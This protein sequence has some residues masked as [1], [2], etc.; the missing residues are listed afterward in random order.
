MS[1]LH[2]EEIRGDVRI[3]EWTVRRTL[4]QIEKDGEEVH[5]EPKVMDLLLCLTEHRGQVVSKDVL[6]DRVWGVEHVS[7]GTLS[8]AVAELRRALGDDART[9]RY[10]ETIRKR[11]YR[12]IA[13][14]TSEHLDEPILS[15]DRRRGVRPAQW[16]VVLVLIALAVGAYAI[17]GLWIGR[18][19]TRPPR[20]VIL[21][22]ENFGEP[23]HGP[24]AAGLTDEVIG[25][26]ATVKQL[27]VI[28]ATTAFHY[29]SSG[30]SARDVARDLD[31][32]YIL[33][34]SVRWSTE[35]DPPV[36]R[37]SPQLIRAVDDS[38][39]WSASFDR[40]PADVLDL[41]SEIARKI[42][43]YLEL[44]LT[45]AESRML[46]ASPTNNPAAYR[47]YLEAIERRGSFSHED[48]TTAA[49]MFRR[50]VEAD[51]DFAQAWAGLAETS[52]ALY[53][54]GYDRRP[55]RC[56]T[57]RRALDRAKE[58]APEA[59]ETMRAAAFYTYHCEG[60]AAAARSDF[61]TALL[62]WPGDTLAM[63]GMAYACRRTGDWAGAEG[64][65]RR[66]LELDPENPTVLWNLGTVLSAKHHFSEALTLIDRAIA[67]GPELR[68]A[69]FAKIFALWQARGDTHGAAAV[70]ERI[71]GVRDGTW[72]GYAVTNACYEGDYEAAVRLARDSPPSFDR[73]RLLCL[74]A[75][76]AGNGTAPELCADAISHY[77]ELRDRDPDS[78]WPHLQLA[79]CRSLAGRHD[80]AL[81]EA[82][83]ALA[84]RSYD[85]DA[86]GRTEAELVL[87]QV[88]ARAGNIE[89]A[90]ERVEKLL[91][92]PS[93]LSPALLRIDPL[94]SPVRH[95][96]RIEKILSSTGPAHG[97]EDPEPGGFS[98]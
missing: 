3:G 4:N 42:V 73:S 27:R 97:V 88:L 31:V 32:D 95:H 68:S 14:V 49:Q 24:F 76:L 71:P 44:R 19:T 80:E 55:A 83:T 28:S 70:L 41:Q 63:R 64:W 26:L 17:S 18:D 58:L 43:E 29:D 92:I 90:V 33:E 79:R 89:S 1:R 62:H 30:K 45:I 85:V 7:E 86:L 35:Q 8:H 60:D 13:Q 11:G 50:A 23:E 65:F 53:H 91:A 20:I 66:A 51:P 59:P 82:E 37:I 25:R 81:R 69:H 74:T 52:G 56:E 16:V 39:V 6:L 46:A 94:W 77:G 12:L 87:A 84:L 57:A 48:I 61:E 21:P 67:F 22:F 47:A 9:P 38:H 36:V 15:I 98:G 2:P 75:V 34:G 72:F 54:L 93:D 5:L 40:H 10:I 96:P 78:L